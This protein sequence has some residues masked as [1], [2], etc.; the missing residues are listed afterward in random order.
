MKLQNHTINF[1]KLQAKRLKR[2]LNIKHTDA[3]NIVAKDY[4]FTNWIDCQRNIT[5]NAESSATTTIPLNFTSWLR[6]QINRNSPL[7]DLARDVKRDTQ[8]PLYDDLESYNIYLHSKGVSG[9]VFIVLK[10]A[11][12]S[13]TAYLTRNLL[14]KEKKIL[15]LQS[16]ILILEE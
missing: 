10:N 7:G 1:Y 3:L 2:E 9:I 11:W 6:K 5:S 12:K 8:W 4:G 15:N 16:E 13:F 14:P